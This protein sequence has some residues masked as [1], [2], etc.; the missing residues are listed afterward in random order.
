MDIRECHAVLSRTPAALDALLRGL[1]GAWIEARDGEDSW[2]PYDVVGHLLHGDKTDWMARLRIIL[3]AG[4][5]HDFAP[6]DR[7]AQFEESKGLGLNELLDRFA[8]LRAENL[9]ELARIDPTAEQLTRTGVH[10]AFGEVT[11]KQLLATWAVHDL[12]HIAQISRVMARRYRTD[13]GP[14]IEYLPI[15][16]RA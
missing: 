14:W 2:S 3:S 8:A 10:P 6:F 7:F 13:V 1:P 12:G 4:E 5:D 11:L 15:L 9:A 16:T